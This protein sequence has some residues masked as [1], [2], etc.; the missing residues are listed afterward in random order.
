M[1]IGESNPIKSIR[2]VD[3]DHEDRSKT[4]VSVMDPMEKPFESATEL[5]GFGW[6]NGDCIAVDTGVTEIDNGPVAALTLRDHSHGGNMEIRQVGNQVIG[7]DQP[8]FLLYHVGHLVTEKGNVKFGGLM[9]A[10][11]DGGQFL[12]RSPRRRLE[13]DRHSDAG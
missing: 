4:A 2:E 13:K 10:A 9:A 7:Y 8:E 11:G 6:S 3:L 5:H 1:R 12:G